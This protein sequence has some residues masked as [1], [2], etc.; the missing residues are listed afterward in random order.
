MLNGFNR[1]GLAGSELGDGLL[2]KRGFTV[3]AVGWEF[4]VR[5]QPG[6][7]RIEVPP[8]SEGGRPVLPVVSGL[9]TPN[10]AER[11]F[12]VGDLAG[13]SPVDPSGPDTKL[14]IR[15]AALGQPQIVPRASWTLSGNTVSTTAAPFEPGRIYELTYR[16]SSAPVSGLGLAAVRD[17]AAWIKHDPGA[18]AR[19]QY[20]YA[21]GSS[22]SGRFLRT[23]LYQG[24]NSDVE[25]R[26]VF[27]GV[28]AHISGAA[29]ID[30]NRRGAT[31]TTLGGFSATECPFAENAQRDPVS[32]V[33][34]GLLDN[35]RARRNQPK[36]SSPT[37]ASSTRAADGPPR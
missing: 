6:V 3:V 28:M 17:V 22:Q 16:A 27:D 10:E 18:L 23:F 4:D 26:Q 32:G 7:I 21:F 19:A 36:I 1:A 24:F 11:S 33:T 20:M 25:G 2:M 5:S 12:T 15:T 31:P 13:Y 29:R 37:P 34:E 35:D 8:A 9:F 30:V 14:T